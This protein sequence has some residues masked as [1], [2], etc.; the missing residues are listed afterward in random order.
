MRAIARRLKRLE[1]R[2]GT[3]EES[4]ETRQLG[5]RLEAADRRCGLPAD[6]AGALGRAHNADVVDPISIN[7]PNANRIYA[8]AM[9]YG[10]DFSLY[11]K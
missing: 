5:L 3:A 4:W 11:A 7:Q 1:E 6:F 2:F 8:I 10:I 9:E